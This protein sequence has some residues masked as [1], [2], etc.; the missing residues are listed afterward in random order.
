MATF[1][2]KLR[3][4]LERAKGFQELLRGEGRCLIALN[5]LYL[6]DLP[7]ELSVKIEPVLHHRFLLPIQG[8]FL[9]SIHEADNDNEQEYAHFHETEESQAAEMNSPGV[10]ENHF[11]IED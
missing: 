2:G 1:E 10:E 6:Q 4:L 8:A 3:V 5:G 11:D 7:L 9:P